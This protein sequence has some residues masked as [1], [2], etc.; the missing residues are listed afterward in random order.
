MN[1]MQNRLLKIFE[2]FH[3]F[4]EENGL[5]YVAIAGTL[6]GAFRHKGFIPW[7]DDL[8]VAMP[9]PDYER[10]LELTKGLEHTNFV[11]EYPDDK[12]DFVYP[13]AKVYDKKSTL[14]ENSRYKTKRGLFLDVFILDGA[15]D[16]YEEAKDTQ[17][18]FYKKMN[19]HNMLVCGFRK[20]R[21]LYKNVAVFLGRFLPINHLK[22]T[23]KANADATKKSY[24]DS[25]Y[26]AIMFGDY[27]EREII[28]KNVIGEPKLIPFENLQIYA[29]EKSDYWLARIY[30]N[31]M[32]LPPPEKRFSHHDFISLD[33]NKGYME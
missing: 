14:I 21:K 3:G 10:F 18:Y 28:E 29:P 11:V 32:Q 20:G 24:D 16:T 30:G 7:D 22:L 25:R 2:W 8:D 23:K 15:G 12:K 13:I 6:L 9:R 26:V 27:G 31:Y 17:N 4:C 33:L 19:L 1:E 5:R